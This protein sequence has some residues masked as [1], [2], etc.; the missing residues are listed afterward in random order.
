MGLKE[1]ER[2]RTLTHSVN[3]KQRNWSRSN[4]S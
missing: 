2:F 4:R 3:V 1:K